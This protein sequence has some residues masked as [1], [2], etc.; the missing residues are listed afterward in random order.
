MRRFI[1]AAVVLAVST[2]VFA[3]GPLL[4]SRDFYP[5]PE[6]PVGF[7]GDGTGWFAGAAPVSGW[8]DGEAEQIEQAYKDGHG[9]D[10]TAKVWML[11]NRQPSNIVWRTE[12]PGW[13]NS[14][15]IVVGDK[16]I[17]TGEPDL[18]I[19]ADANTGRI[20]WT[21]EINPWLCAGLDAELAERLR[22]MSLIH[23]ALD[24]FITVQF[25]FGTVVEYYTH[26]KYVPMLDIFINDDLPVIT[27]ALAKLDPD[28]NYDDPAREMTEKL[29]NWRE[30]PGDDRAKRGYERQ[31]GQLR[32]AV[33]RRIRDLS[34]REINIPL[35]V[36]WGN[37]SGRNR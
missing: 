33:A 17:T 29:L 2:S 7:R 1:A 21:R 34:G 19:C 31:V 28:G 32:G 9:R 20:L 10:R 3:N 24:A 30:E 26:E 11:K 5:S 16:V 18:L 22:E 13:V 14:Q 35:G 12:M 27:A 36:P 4:G 25:A 37:P 23:T 15:P 8:S 6:R